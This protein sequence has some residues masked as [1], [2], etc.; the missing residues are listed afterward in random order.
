MTATRSELIGQIDELIRGLN[1]RGQQRFAQRLEAF[2]LTAPQ[3]LTLAAIAQLG[4]VVTMSEVSDTLQLPR[5]SM[6]SM[7]DRLVELGLAV[8]GSLERDRR[9][10]TVTI[11]AAGTDLLRQVH[12][13]NL[14]D[15]TGMVEGLEEDD[16][17]R[18][19]HVLSVLLEAMNHEPA[20]G[21][22]VSAS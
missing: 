16:L 2:D 15:L 7:T 9:A 8:R 1:W 11:T 14:A 12:A 6:T 4:P 13:M 10:V 18:F 3:Y 20:G 19:A 21:E 17:S 5:S 22:A